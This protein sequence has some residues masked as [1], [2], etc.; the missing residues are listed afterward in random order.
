MPYGILGI[1]KRLAIGLAHPAGSARDELAQSSQQ[2]KSSYWFI[3]KRHQKVNGELTESA[4]LSTDRA[5]SA[6]HGR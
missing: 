5:T 6:T 1:G 4:R 3:L 2:S